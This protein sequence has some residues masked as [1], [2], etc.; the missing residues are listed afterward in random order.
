MCLLQRLRTR[1]TRT[2]A[3]CCA[4]REEVLLGSAAAAVHAR[5]ASTDI[6]SFAE[7]P[8]LVEAWMS[9]KRVL[10]ATTS[11]ESTSASAFLSKRMLPSST[12]T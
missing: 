12:I 8:S 4:D 10:R 2:F 1:T 7:Q 6:G 9:D 3:S 11:F 5:T